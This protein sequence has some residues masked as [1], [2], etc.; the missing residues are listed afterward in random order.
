GGDGRPGGRDREADQGG[1]DQ[2]R[3]ALPPP[4]AHE[5][6]GSQGHAD[7]GDGERP[8]HEGHGHER[9]PGE[10]GG[11]WARAC[12]PTPGRRGGGRGGEHGANVRAAP[13]VTTS[14]GADVSRAVRDAAR[15]V[16]PVPTPAVDVVF[17][18]LDEAAALPWVLG[19][20]PAGYRPIVVDNGSTDGSAA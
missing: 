16:V 5:R 20:V 9:R 12:G 4:V 14:P 13:G 8:P 2:P 6:R 19:R 3:A 1:H 7:P 18:V 10:E 15:T 17:P 11:H